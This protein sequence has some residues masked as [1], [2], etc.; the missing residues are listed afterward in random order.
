MIRYFVNVCEKNERWAK[1]HHEIVKNIKMWIIQFM[2][3]NSILIIPFIV[4]CSIKN[5]D[6]MKIK[7]NDV[8]FFQLIQFYFVDSLPLSRLSTFYKSL[9]KHIGIKKFSNK[10][11]KNKNIKAFQDLSFRIH[12]CKFPRSIRENKNVKLFYYSER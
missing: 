4:S 6:L 8:Y 2:W 3:W 11:Q 5:C 9:F 12:I 7:W 10:S 1:H